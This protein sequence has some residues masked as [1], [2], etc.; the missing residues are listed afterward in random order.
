MKTLRKLSLYVKLDNSTFKYVTALKQL[1]SLSVK[2]HEIT[3]A[4]ILKLADMPNL[5]IVNVKNCTKLTDS[6]VV[7]LLSRKPLLCV[8][9]RPHAVVASGG[10]LLV[11]SGKK[12][13]AVK[14]LEDL[15]KDYVPIGITIHEKGFTPE[16]INHYVSAYYPQ[17]PFWE[18]ADLAGT[19]ANDETVEFLLG[20][21]D[22]KLRRLNL[23]DTAIT[24]AAVKDL[25]AQG[26]LLEQLDVRG[27]KVTKE[28]VEYFKA[29]R[30]KCKVWSDFD[31]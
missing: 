21:A 24:D 18:Q 30:P 27:T 26:P 10:V 14:Q 17:R 1:E 3:D 20:S 19:K 8:E 16:A 4:A 6:G 29:K 23:K 12:E 22:L 5:R 2:S 25:A 28:V 15:P 7:N 9:K 31:G 13:I 11:K